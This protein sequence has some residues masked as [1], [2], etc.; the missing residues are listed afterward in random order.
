MWSMNINTHSIFRSFNNFNNWIDTCI[1]NL[2]N[3]KYDHKD[4]CWKRLWLHPPPPTSYLFD[5]SVWRV[6][7]YRGFRISIPIDS[8]GHLSIDL[9]L[10][11]RH[12]QC[13]YDC[14]FQLLRWSLSWMIF[15]IG[16]KLF[17]SLF[18]TSRF[19]AYNQ[20]FKYTN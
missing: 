4:A 5:A 14:S 2:L 6:W 13:R 9:V 18:I 10:F 16:Q 1:C 8:I 11:Y 7:W 17:F 3:I 20:D 12:Q 15:H 19:Q